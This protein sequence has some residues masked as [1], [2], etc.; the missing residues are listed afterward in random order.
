L[1]QNTFEAGEI[2]RLDERHQRLYYTA[3]SGDNP[4]KLQLHCAALDGGSGRRLTDPGFHH[5]VDV[6]P[7]GDYF[8]DT[9]QTHDTPP[10][11]CL[12]NGDGELII[13][14]ARSDTNK[15]AKLG[16]KKVELF[17]FKA[18]DEQTELYGML[19]FPSNFSP[20]KKY[21]LLITVYAGPATSGASETFTL[22]NAIT[23]LGFLVA[24]LDS[25]SANGRGKK[26]LDVIYQNL[27]KVEIDD[28]AAGVKALAARRYVN[29]KQV[30]IFGTSYG[31]TASLLCL[32]RYPD[33]FQAACSCSPV[34]DFRNYDTIY[35]ERYFGLPQEHPIAYD[36]VC[37]M[38]YV[39]QLKG[40]L[41]LYYGTADDNVHPSNTLQLVKAL[42]HAGKSFELQVGPDAGHSSV[43]RD[44]MMEFFIEAL[45]R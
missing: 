34:T 29:P 36:Q 16:L 40:R 18:A 6:S 9:F 24:A 28:Q 20:H 30:G 10:V 3:R 15:F 43:N 17:E 1:T 26:F 13:E 5:S 19:H 23:E 39:N 22:P 42:Q 41:M 21:P 11:T 14:L 37:A 38:N 44:R 8:I 27:G 25:R 7:N 31:G 32:M 2:A 33:V 4:M 12:R 35:T 45:T